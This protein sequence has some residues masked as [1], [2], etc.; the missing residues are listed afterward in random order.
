MSPLIVSHYDAQSAAMQ[1]I[2]ALVN[3]SVVQ[4]R[5]VFDLY[6]LSTQLSPDINSRIKTDRVIVKTACENVSSVSFNQFR[7]TVLSYLTEEDKASYDNP[8][9]WDEIKLKVN[10]LICENQ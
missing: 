10:Y 6:L 3:R 9:I 4:A 7:D 1:K 2:N 8:D 5:D